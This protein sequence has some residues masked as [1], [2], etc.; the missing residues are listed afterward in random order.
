MT[1]LQRLIV[2]LD[3]EVPYELVRDDDGMPKSAYAIASH[4]NVRV[5]EAPNGTLD[6]GIFVAHDLYAEDVRKLIEVLS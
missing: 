6:A 3:G 1:E 4:G 5:S 2:M